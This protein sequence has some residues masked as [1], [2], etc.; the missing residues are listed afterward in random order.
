MKIIGYLIGGALLGL[1]LLGPATGLYLVSKDSFAALHYDGTQM[2]EIVDCRSF[3]AGG[4][5][6]RYVR[7]PVVRRPTQSTLS[8]SVDEVPYLWE[9]DDHIG[10]YVEVIYDLK[11]P[12][13]AKIN[14]FVEMWFLPL[15]IG[16]VCLLWYGAIAIGYVRKYRRRH[17][18]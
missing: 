2:V 10:T 7:V 15:V 6:S 3:R 4:Q 9:C 11:N 5:H 16:A 18:R 13:H 8:G 1:V 14:T 12:E 17:D